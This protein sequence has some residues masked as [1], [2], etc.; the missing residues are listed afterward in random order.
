MLLMTNNYKF[1]SEKKNV[2]R[3]CIDD[4]I[5]VP[6]ILHGAI[7]NCLSLRT[8]HCGIW[9]LV[10]IFLDDLPPYIKNRKTNE[11]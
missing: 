1:V 2:Y 5:I 10:T 11:L 7:L 8:N 4:V 6:D 3:L 9:Y